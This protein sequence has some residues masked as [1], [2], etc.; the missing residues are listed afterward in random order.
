MLIHS[1]KRS[2][3]FWG[4]L[5]VFGVGVPGLAQTVFLDGLSA[6]GDTVRFQLWFYSAEPTYLAEMDLTLYVLN[7]QAAQIDEVVQLK[8]GELVAPLGGL[9]P[10]SWSCRKLRSEQNYTAIRFNLV[11]RRPQNRGQFEEMAPGSKG[12]PAMLGEFALVGLQL[13]GQEQL[14]WRWP[15]AKDVYQNVC[16]KLEEVAPFNGY[17]IA[18]KQE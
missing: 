4:L 12:A 10:V 18:L 2:Q 3:L 6:K 15:E 17:R 11:S 8:P 7:D 9:V 13:E 14:M 1:I 16:I 5:F